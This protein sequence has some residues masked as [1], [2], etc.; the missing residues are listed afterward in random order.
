MAAPLGLVLLLPRDGSCWAPHSSLSATL[1]KSSLPDIGVHIHLGIYVLLFSPLGKGD[2][3][4]L[5]TK[6]LCSSS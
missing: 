4:T 6:P 3:L 2:W 1:G 5:G